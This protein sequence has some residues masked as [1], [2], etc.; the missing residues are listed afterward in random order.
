MRA[1]RATPITESTRR[2]SRSRQPPMRWPCRYTMIY[3]MPARR[4]R[5]MTARMTRGGLIRRSL[6]SLT[7]L[8]VNEPGMTLRCHRRQ[9]SFASNILMAANFMLRATCACARRF[10]LAKRFSMGAA[11]LGDIFDAAPG[12]LPSGADYF[13]APAHSPPMPRHAGH[14]FT[15]ADTPCPA[16]ISAACEAYFRWAFLAAGRMPAL[17]ICR[18][19]RRAAMP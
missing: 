12:H 14:Y 15:P 5:D 17:T 8:S 9:F 6:A 18:I 16:Y 10:L 3:R 4:I 2:A 1:C 13:A 7:M 11:A 19:S